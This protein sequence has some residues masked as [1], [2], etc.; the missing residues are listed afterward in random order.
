MII[1]LQ[2][3][4]S[5]TTSRSSGG[6]GLA[7][8]FTRLLHSS[9][10]YKTSPSY[11]EFMRQ[12]RASLRVLFPYLRACQIAAKAVLAWR[13]RKSYEK[14]KNRK[15]LVQNKSLLK[16]KQQKEN[17]KLVQSVSEVGVQGNENI[18][19]TKLRM[20]EE[21]VLTLNSKKGSKRG[22]ASEKERLE[23][24]RAKKGIGQLN[25]TREDITVDGGNA[26]RGEELQSEGNDTRQSFV[27]NIEKNIVQE[28][29]NVMDKGKDNDDGALLDALF[30]LHP[31]VER[32]N[33]L[34]RSV[35]AREENEDDSLRWLL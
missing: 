2:T 11:V 29:N 16:R 4:L 22:F 14:E 26:E 1:F 3:S 5:C 8:A 7:A 20:E 28:N 6:D 10:T 9:S 13:K 24:H 31:T 34:N 30:S 23:I 21:T 19:L 12:E 35:C 33:Q 17:E 25:S 15:S 27:A 32:R 18:I